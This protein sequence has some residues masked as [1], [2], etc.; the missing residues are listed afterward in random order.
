MARMMFGA[1]LGLPV[2]VSLVN[3][4][5][6]DTPTG[7][8]LGMYAILARALCTAHPE[9]E[10][11]RCTHREAE[12]ATFV[13]KRKGQPEVELSWTHEDSV[14]AGLVGRGDKGDGKLTNNHDKYAKDM[15]VA[16]ASMAIV[17]IVIPECLMGLYAREEFPQTIDVQASEVAPQAPVRDWTAEKS[18]IVT[19]IEHAETD[20][21]RKAVRHRIKAYVSDGGPDS[22][23]LKSYY[24][25]VHGPKPKAA[26][27]AEPPA[28]EQS[29]VGK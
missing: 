15:N 26:P 18:A 21:Q 25:K 1:S 10:Y 6:I 2:M 20:E 11:L 13:C 9:C 28:G 22:A 16:R 7:P 14:K 19:E 3:L 4:F 5:T 23:T 29:G 17:Q 24:D 12:K 8:K 27:A